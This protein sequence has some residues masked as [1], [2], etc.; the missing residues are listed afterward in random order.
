MCTIGIDT[1]MQH[2][3]IMSSGDPD[4]AIVE[5]EATRIAKS[6]ARALKDSR[7]RCLGTGTTTATWGQP[8]WTGLHGTMGAPKR[9]YSING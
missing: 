7:Q 5:A 1:A 6:A 4:Y 2:D 8:T 9:R 3:T